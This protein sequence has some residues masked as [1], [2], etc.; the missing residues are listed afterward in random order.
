MRELLK[1]YGESIEGQPLTFAIDN[2]L[3]A[4]SFNIEKCSV[5]NSKKLPLWLSMKNWYSEKDLISILFKCG[6]DIR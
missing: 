5:L 3:R 1:R 4:K 2:R 6:D